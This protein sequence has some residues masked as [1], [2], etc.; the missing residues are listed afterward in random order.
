[1]R[2]PN[3]EVALATYGWMQNYFKLVGDF[4]PNRDNEIHLEPCT[5]KSIYD[6]Y[7]FDMDQELYEE[8]T[9]SNRGFKL[10]FS[11]FCEFW[12]LIFPTVRIREFKAVSGKC[13]VCAK[14]SELRKSAINK[15][16]KQ[17]ITTLHSLHRSAYMGER[18]AYALRKQD[19][20]NFDKL[21]F[22]IITDG[23]AQTHCELPH[24]ANISNFNNK[25]KQHLQGVLI[26]GKGMYI[27]RTFHTIKNGSN[28]Q[29]HTMLM[30]LEKLRDKELG[31]LPNTFYYQIAGGC[32]NCFVSM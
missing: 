13:D 25:L 16:G 22:S 4:Q 11:S 14:L 8:K 1:M 12:K 23:M 18:L 26:H 30:T 7:V 27:F 15:V 6:E 29:I 2:I 32:K 24:M 20:I 31:Q 21:Y 10:Q 17:Q 19:A 9:T 28:L 5:V 3:T